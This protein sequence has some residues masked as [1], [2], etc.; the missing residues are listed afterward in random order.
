[1]SKLCYDILYV[2]YGEI[3]ISETISNT[4]Q[5]HNLIVI[6]NPKRL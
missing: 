5:N 4:F 2:A 1:M 3:C 6:Y